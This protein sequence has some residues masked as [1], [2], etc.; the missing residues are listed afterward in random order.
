MGP[1]L[2]LTANIMFIGVHCTLC[3]APRDNRFALAALIGLGVADSIFC[4]VIWSCFALVMPETL[5]GTGCGIAAVGYNISLTLSSL[6]VGFLADTGD[7]GVNYYENVELFLIGLSALT[8]AL[9]MVL[10]L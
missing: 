10:I 1:Y 8:A 6:L 2:I 9:T 4:S 5:I 7:D 3:M